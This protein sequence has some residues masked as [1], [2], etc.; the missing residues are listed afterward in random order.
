MNEKREDTGFLC[1]VQGTADEA[2][3]SPFLSLPKVD[4]QRGRG[5]VVDVLCFRK[6]CRSD[7]CKI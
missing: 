2:F 6:G 7:S 1:Q 3:F 4:F 5:V